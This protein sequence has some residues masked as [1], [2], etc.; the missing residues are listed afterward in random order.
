VSTGAPDTRK[1]HVIRLVGTN[2]NGDVLQDVWVD[3]ERMDVI[4]AATQTR[5]NNWQG[6]QRKLKWLDDP[7]GD[8]YFPED[9]GNP[10]RKIDT[11]KLYDVD[12]NGVTDTPDEWIE[13]QVIRQMKSAG[14]NG[15]WQ[16]YQH[17]HV[18]D[19]DGSD[20]TT[21]RKFVAQRFYHYDT[22]I[23]DD[24]QAAFDGD[25]TL[26]AYVVQGSDYTIDPSTKDTDQWIE[27]EVLT[28][29]KASGNMDSDSWQGHQ[30]K[31]LNQY[32]IDMSVPASGDT[33]GDGTNP[34]F[35]LDPY[36]NII[37]INFGAL[38]VEFFNGAA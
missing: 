12:S 1:T 4:K 28:S 27:H 20:S 32:L 34:P 23:D 3:I 17:R 37:N 30:A 18:N 10:A 16:G 21:T 9:Q 29:F 35:R 38:A 14:G 19:T 33:G 6:H 24:A 2:A 7:Q 25:P 31:L 26:K 5:E 8:D 11:I 36:Q 13:V 22:N 15:S